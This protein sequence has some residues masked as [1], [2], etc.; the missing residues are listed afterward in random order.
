MNEDVVWINLKVLARIPPYHRLNTHNELFYIEKN[1]LWNPV[2]LW[3]FFRGDN[4]EAAIKRIDDLVEKATVMLDKITVN[5][6][7]RK[8]VDH[9]V[10]AK[11]G[12]QNLQK[13]YL[14]DLTMTASIE[15]L[16]DKIENVLPIDDTDE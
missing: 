2:A 5:H 10:G 4:R 14:E 12:L 8:L 15:R 13:T 11:Q 1:S 9:L 3:R 6:V 7:Y 16:L